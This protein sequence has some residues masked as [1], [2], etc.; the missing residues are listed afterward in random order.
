MAQEIKELVELDVEVGLVIGGGPATQVQAYLRKQF[1]QKTSVSFGLSS[2]RGGKIKV[3]GTDTGQRTERD[4]IRLYANTFVTPTVQ[5]QGML[6]KD[7]NSD[8]GFRND[9]VAEL[10][11][12][13]VF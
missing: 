13:K 12:L 7:V 10:R 5:V 4:Q 9:V 6:A 1:G 8:G 2:Q 11:F 3:G